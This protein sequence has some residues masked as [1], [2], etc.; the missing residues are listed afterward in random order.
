VWHIASL[1]E[2]PIEN[3]CLPI[4]TKAHAT[5][6]V[7]SNTGIKSH[8]TVQQC[9]QLELSASSKNCLTHGPPHDGVLTVYAIAVNDQPLPILQQPDH[10][11]A[12]GAPPSDC[13]SDCQYTLNNLCADA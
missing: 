10:S 9:S 8:I 7:S 11:T 1:A 5:P 3:S 12:A 2:D 6:S 4:A 13:R